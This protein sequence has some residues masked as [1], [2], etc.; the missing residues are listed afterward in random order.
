MGSL[1]GLLQSGTCMLVG[2]MPQLICFKENDILKYFNSN[3]DNCFIVTGIATHNSVFEPLELYPNPANGMIFLHVN[4]PWILPMTITFYD[5]V[6]KPILEKEVTEAESKIDLSG[7]PDTGL[8]IF[9]WKGANGVS[10]SGEI[11]NKSK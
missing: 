6:G 1:F 11:L 5:P 7:I 2:D 10:Q 8:I 9:L 4:D 3:F